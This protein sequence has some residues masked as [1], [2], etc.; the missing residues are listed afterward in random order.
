M[1]PRLSVI[2]GDK[3]PA[4]RLADAQAELERLV[5]EEGEGLLD[6][7]N[8]LRRRMTD[9]A[10]AA[11]LP[12]GMGDLTLEANRMAANELRWRSALANGGKR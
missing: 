11:T 1:S 10:E 4:K 9:F 6:E 2:P 12:P 7:L 5:R 8:A 3:P